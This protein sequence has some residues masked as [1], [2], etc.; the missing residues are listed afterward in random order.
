MNSSFW[1]A[2]EQRHWAPDPNGQQRKQLRRNR[3]LGSKFLDSSLNGS[4]KSAFGLVTSVV[5]KSD[6]QQLPL[7]KFR[8]KTVPRTALPGTFS[9]RWSTLVCW[10]V[11]P[12]VVTTR[13]FRLFFERLLELALRIL[14]N[15]HQCS[16]HCMKYI[17]W[18]ARE[19]RHWAR[20]HLFDRPSHNIFSANFLAKSL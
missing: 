7:K 8:Y 16:V 17:F 5:I 9:A 18:L 11:F 13:Q 20:K 19:Q 6:F 15:F 1:P 2:R 10:S 14:F 3:A 12:W 4:L